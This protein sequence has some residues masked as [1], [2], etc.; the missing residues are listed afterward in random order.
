MINLH[1]FAERFNELMFYEKLTVKELANDTGLI[2]STIYNYLKSNRLPVVSVLIKL[3]DYFKCSVDFLLALT[4]DNSFTKIIE[5][6]PF[7]VQF[8][9]LVKYFNKTKYRIAKDTDITES[10]IYT[11]LNGS[12]VPNIE[13]IL[14][15]AKYFDCTIDAILG[16]ELLI[17]KEKQ[18]L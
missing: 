13:S 17:S 1:I 7:A 15:L 3:A 11:W 8:P 9:I 4:D 2:P 5:C 14:R 12:S 18:I 16:R 6:P 10:T